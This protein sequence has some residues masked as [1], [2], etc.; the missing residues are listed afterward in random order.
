M[1]SDSP[2]NILVVGHRGMKKLFP[3]NTMLSFKEALD[4]RCDV[5]ETDV[6]MTR[7]GILVICHDESVNRTT[8]GKGKVSDFTLKEIKELDAGIGFS[9]RFAGVK[10]P[11]LREFLELTSNADYPVLLNVEIKEY[12]EAVCDETIKEIEEYGMAERTVIASFSAWVL[13]Y[14]HSIRPDM[15]LQGFPGRYMSDFTEETYK[16][17]YGMGIPYEKERREQV[18]SDIDFA[19]SVGVHPWLYITDSEEEVKD[20]VEMGAYIVTGN[21]PTGGIRYLAKAG[22]HKPFYENV[23]PSGKMKASI[24]YGIGDLRTETVDIPSAKDGEVLIEVKR[25]GICGS[26]IGRILKKGTY[27][28]PTVPGHE[29]SGRVV[30][31]PENELNGQRVAVFP[32]LPCFECENCK[33]KRYVLCKNYDYYGSRRDGGFE[34]Y[35][36]VKRFNI[37]PLPDNVTY[38]EGSM[39]EPASVGLRAVKTLGNVEGKTLLITG[40]G[41]VGLGAGM[42]ASIRG[43]KDVFF[44]DIDKRKTAFAEKLGFK[45][46]DKSSKSEFDL[47][48]EG[49]G[50]GSALSS[51]IKAVKTGSKI[52]LL[53]NPG[54]DVTLNPTD[55]QLILRKELTLKGTW[56]SSYACEDDDWE[57]TLEAISSGK[58]PLRQMITQIIS[59]E[60]LPETI[61]KISERDGFFCKV[62]VNNE[63]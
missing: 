45:S 54:G 23:M 15:K 21:D 30:Y 6:R 35:L 27:H 49:T 4:R 2:S 32:L 46:F 34:K 22:L 33:K 11:T 1:W 28:F 58:L 44:S 57:E 63:K 36:A 59:L 20:A 62:T 5:I 17:I 29:F 25:C 3:E 10:I 19:I 8:N 42:W 60:E 26:D 53:G 50:A 40:A 41:P 12:T 52:V 48:I 51:V 18:K 9:P 13:R 16:I 39:C 47:A 31:D 37:I 55:Y 7:D 56:N 43:A 24:L 14:V 61:K 38:E